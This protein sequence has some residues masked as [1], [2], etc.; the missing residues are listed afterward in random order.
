MQA[1]GMFEPR[2]P[3]A[4]EMTYLFW[5]LVVLGAAVAMM[6]IGLLVRALFREPPGDADENRLQRRWLVGGGMA[7]PALVIGVVFGFTLIGMRNTDLG[8]GSLEIDV[9]GHQW[10]WEV[11]Y[12]GFVTANEIHIP[13]GEPVTFTL[14]S[15]DVIHSFWVPELGGKIDL[16]PD[17][18]N[19]VTLQ[20]DEAGVYGGACAEFCGL[21]HARMRLQVHAESREDYEQWV[22]AQ[23]GG[24]SEP[25]SAAAER[26]LEIFLTEG[27]GEC[28]TVAGVTEGRKAP[29]LTHLAS[30]SS[31][32]AGTL[33]NDSQHLADWIS[34]PESFKQGTEMPG[35]DLDENDLNDLVAY[36]E[37]LR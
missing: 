1:A 33:P 24:A 21:Q 7:M 18:P 37:S 11:R 10:W 9:I 32:A 15:A 14:S 13:V 16:L 34:D 2:G 26:G 29:D 30:R 35:A 27:C 4:A 31:L 6:F 17:H 20:A 3:V 19:S 25:D 28:H 36:L 23:Q 5:V 22:A 8:P 12:D